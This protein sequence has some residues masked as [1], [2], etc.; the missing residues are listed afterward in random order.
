[1]KKW[2]IIGVLF[3]GFAPF[4]KAQDLNHSSRST[5]LYEQVK[6]MKQ[7]IDWFNVYL[8]MQGSFD[9]YLDDDREES[10]AFKMGQLRLEVQGNVTD[11]I[12]FTITIVN[13]TTVTISTAAILN[14]PR[15]PHY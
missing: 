3:L 15:Q 1:M 10:T 6:Q 12:Y 8:N 13:T 14:K 2:I 7:K 5:T 11:R 4:L 9:I